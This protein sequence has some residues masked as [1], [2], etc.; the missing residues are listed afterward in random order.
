MMERICLH[1][2]DFFVLMHILTN[3]KIFKNKH[4]IGEK[5]AN[6]LYISYYIN[7]S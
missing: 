1:K 7:Y 5:V 2:P 4:T 6:M 3:Y